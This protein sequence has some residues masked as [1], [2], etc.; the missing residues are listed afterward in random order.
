[1]EGVYDILGFMAGESL[2]THQLPRVG[3]EAKPVILRQ[4]PQLADAAAEAEQITQDNWRDWLDTWIARYG[5]TL[6]IAPFAS[7][8]RS[9]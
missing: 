6:P 1:M 9:G 2:F 5:E 8:R 4:H 7:E 3:Q